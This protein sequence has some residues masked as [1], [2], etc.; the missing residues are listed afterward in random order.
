MPFA[1]GE[2]LFDLLLVAPDFFNGEI[3]VGTIDSL[4]KQL[5][6]FRLQPKLPHDVDL[7]I[8]SGRRRQ[9]DR[10]RIADQG[11]ELAQPSVVGSKVMPPL[12]DAV[13][14]IHCQQS[15]VAAGNHVDE[16]GFAK[17]LRRDVQQAV[18]ALRDAGVSRLSLVARQRRVDEGCVNPAL[19]ERVNLILHQRDQRRHHERQ[20]NASPGIGTTPIGGL[21]RQQRGDL[22]AQRLP[23]PRRHD[24]QRMPAAE[25][26]TDD[27]LLRTAK[28][29]ETEIP[30]QYV[31][32]L[33]VRIHVALPQVRQGDSI[34]LEIIAI[35]KDTAKRRSVSRFE[36]CE[37]AATHAKRQENVRHPV[38]SHENQGVKQK[39]PCLTGACRPLRSL[40]DRRLTPWGFEPQFTD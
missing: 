13:C 29:C 16:L 18:L 40:I 33:H 14:F 8:G 21:Q 30:V 35:S 5:D 3:Q 25:S 7:H 15:H 34:G 11:A 23:A 4:V 2:D 22:V 38:S 32:R 10:R 20:R 6:F 1:H 9:S 37:F 19:P 31:N 28:S 12:T 24:N 26:T 36:F 27:R 39:S 17:P